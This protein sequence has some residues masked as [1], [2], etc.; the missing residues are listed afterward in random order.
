MF[1]Y[2]KVKQ[3]EELIK[4]LQLDLRNSKNTLGQLDAM[5]ISVQDEFVKFKKEHN[6]TL[7]LLEQSKNE[8]KALTENGNI[9]TKSLETA[10][11]TNAENVLANE[12]LI[13]KIN[14]IQEKQVEIIHEES[15]PLSECVGMDLNVAKEQLLEVAIENLIGKLQLEDLLQVEHKDDYDNLRTIL[16][17]NT[18]KK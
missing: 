9:L 5:H 6:E 16:K 13:K 4:N 11:Q 3:L 10:N 8:V 2:K 7:A 17:I 12:Q 1:N 15:V 18:L 14:E